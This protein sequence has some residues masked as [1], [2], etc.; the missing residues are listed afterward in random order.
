MLSYQDPLQ[1]LGGV[2]LYEQVVRLASEKANIKVAYSDG[3]A[4]N[5]TNPQHQ[6]AGITE[7][8]LAA[9]LS[10]VDAKSALLEELTQRAGIGAMVSRLLALHES[11]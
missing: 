6:R 1:V 4:W 3:L 7:A 5:K 2:W 10:A 8:N 11:N 9:T